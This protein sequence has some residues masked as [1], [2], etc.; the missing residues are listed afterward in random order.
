MRNWTAKT[1]LSWTG[2]LNS[3][4]RMPNSKKTM[5]ERMT[6]RM[7]TVNSTNWTGRTKKNSTGCL[8][9]WTGSKS[10]NS[11]GNSRT[12]LTGNWRMKS[13]ATVN[14]RTRSLAMSLTK[15]LRKK[16]FG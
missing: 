4:R 12:N 5:T 16:S 13:F 6:T 11:T 1:S 15:N 3:T 10:L 2:C 8:K 14:L 9:N 7:K